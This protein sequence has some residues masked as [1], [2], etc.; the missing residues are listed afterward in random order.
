MTEQLFKLPPS[1]E[2]CNPS[3]QLNDVPPSAPTPATPTT[4]ADIPQSPKM[5]M[6]DCSDNLVGDK[7]S[8][9]EDVQ[10]EADKKEPALVESPK[11]RRST[12]ER[13]KPD[14]YGKWVEKDKTE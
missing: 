9:F 5:V 1:E 12:R 2:N 8:D 14:Y 13:R 6:P 7:S 4:L 3:I 10:V 11:L